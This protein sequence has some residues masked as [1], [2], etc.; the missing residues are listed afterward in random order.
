MIQELNRLHSLI[1]LVQL[2]R[3]HEEEVLV[4]E[5][6]ADINHH[7]LSLIHKIEGEQNG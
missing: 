2:A 3:V 4:D 6:L 7:I 5:G 1:Q